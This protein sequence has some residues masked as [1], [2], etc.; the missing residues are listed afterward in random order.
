MLNL[1][2]NI[3]DHFCHLFNQI[4][5]MEKLEDFKMMNA[6]L[7]KC[8]SNRFDINLLIIENG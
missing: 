6:L 8:G 7:C 2:S 5:Y 1:P 3:R 4:I